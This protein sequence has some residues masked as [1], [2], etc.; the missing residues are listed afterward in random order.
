MQLAAG[1]ARLTLTWQ[2][3]SSWGSFTKTGYEIG[4]RI[5]DAGTWNH[6]IPRLGHSR[7][8]YSVTQLPKANGYETVTNG[9]KYC[10]Q[11]R[12]VAVN[13]D[14]SSDEIVG[15]WVTKCGTPAQTQSTDATL[16]GLTAAASAGSS[17]TFSALTLTPTFSAATDRYSAAAANEVTHARLTPTVNHSTASVKVGKGSS[18]QPVSS[19][20]SSQAIALNVG[21]NHITV[22]VTAEDTIA[23]K[24]YT[25]TVTRAASTDAT[26]STLTATS[27]TS[28]SGPFTSLPFAPA[29]APATDRYTA[30]VANGIT[31]VKL[32]PTV[33][34]AGK[35]TVEVGEQGSLMTVSSGSASQA[36]AL[37]LGDNVIFAKVTAE[38]TT[39]VSY[40]RVTV[41]RAARPPLSTP[42]VSL[43][44]TTPVGEGS[45]VTVRA[46]LSKELSGD[47]SIP[48]TLSADTA[49]PSDY[50][51][52]STITITAGATWGEGTIATNQDVDT[53]DETFTVTLG[54]ALPSSVTAGSLS[55]VVVTINDDDTPVTT[56]DPS[57][58]TAN[59]S[60][61]PSSV[62]EGSP[63]TVRV[64]L[65]EPAKS[66]VRIFARVTLGTAEPDD[67][68]LPTSDHTINFVFP[69]GTTAFTS[70]EIRTKQ[71]ADTDAETFTVALVNPFPQGVV[72]GSPSSVVVTIQDDDGGGP[73]PGGGGG[74]PPSDDDDDDEDDDGD[75][76][77]P[78]GGGGPPPSDDDDEDDDDDG[79][80]GPPRAAI[81]TDADCDETLC[82][83]LTGERVSFE[84][85]GSGTVRSRLW[86]FGDGGTSRSRAT[87]HVWSEP[88]FYTVTLRLS[89]GEVESTASLTFLVEAAAPA[90]TCMADDETR[91]LRD[92]R[93]AVEMEWWTGDGRS[94]AGKVVREGTNDSAVFQFF[95][96]DNWEVL[97]KVLDGCSINEHVWVYGA[98]ATTLGYR[99]RVTDTVTGAVRE[100]LNEDGRRADAITDA[101]AFAGVCRD[102]SFAAAASPPPDAATPWPVLAGIEAASEALSD[103]WPVGVEAGSEAVVCTESATT[104]CLLDGRYEVS[105]S[106]SAPGA[107]GGESGEAGPGRV[108]RP[109]TP[110]SGLF[111]FFD[112]DNWEM[113]VKVLDGCS[114]N[115][116][117]WVFA[118]SATDLGST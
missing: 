86:D 36:I 89:D 49:E 84:D 67:T 103:P 75:G 74:P 79:G 113:L 109:G 24:T 94:G 85:T 73:P 44:A 55:S 51:S 111:Y 41:T 9:R 104:L 93:F 115:D 48:I 20:G 31:H 99:I 46:T 25:V 110:D 96:E 16:S 92:S 11:I 21:A 50:G 95:E 56:R 70:F 32:T 98:S 4:W 64:T 105:V 28:S 57:P 15:H 23:K 1:D 82:R 30:N 34:D 27:A 7:T 102:R 12:A 13:P 54:S 78:G 38:D 81:T 17:G 88:G 100:Y 6:Y 108:L 40:Y 68:N 107:A 8:S 42:T 19:G 18:L 52:L 29:F 14:D 58:V 90:G 118:A 112:P 87:A 22:E 45:P 106:W 3:P 26:L 117:V 47:V 33:A 76:P 83:A 5:G 97:V 43:S 35:A 66:E 53:D 2:E 116:R 65:S 60:V 72:A 63:V 101:K 37:A 69:E 114:Y 71:D 59:L 39:I 77:P 10:L 61:T 91:C 62:R 80:G